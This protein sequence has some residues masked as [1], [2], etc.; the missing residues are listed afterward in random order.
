MQVELQFIEQKSI[1][2]K[3]KL[4]KAA[5]AIAHFLGNSRKALQQFDMRRLISHRVF[6]FII[7]IAQITSR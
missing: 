1:T 4:I 6:A 2:A 7:H 5:H 3:D